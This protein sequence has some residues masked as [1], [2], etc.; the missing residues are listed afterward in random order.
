MS[1]IQC[2]SSQGMIGVDTR[3]IRNYFTI[4]YYT[5]LQLMQSPSHRGVPLGVPHQLGTPRLG[6]A[7]EFPGVRA[8]VAHAN[9]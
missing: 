2:L 1:V 4:F 6:N 7:S 8:Q 5:P 9:S 3:H